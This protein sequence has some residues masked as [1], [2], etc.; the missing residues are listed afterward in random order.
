ML[1]EVVTTPEAQWQGLAALRASRF[2]GCVL[3]QSASL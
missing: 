2:T 1:D 3:A